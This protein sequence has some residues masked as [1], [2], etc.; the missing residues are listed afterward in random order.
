VNGRTNDEHHLDT[1]AALALGALS[2]REAADA[3]AHL[4]SCDD[5]RREYAMLRPTADAVGLSVAHDVPPEVAARMKSRV[6]DAVRADI[7]GR[8]PAF[9]VPP[10]PLDVDTG[11]TAANVIPFART[12]RRSFAWV[13]YVAAAA[14]FIFAIYSQG[15]LV[16][17]QVALSDATAQVTGLK[18]EVAITARA[19][20]LE[21]ATLADIAAPDAKRYDVPGRGTVIVRGGHAYLSLKGLPALPRGKVYEAWTLANGAKS[22][23]DVKR[24]VTF[25]PA[26]E[27]TLV[28][29]P[30]NARNVADVAIT[31]EPDGGSAKP[32]SAPLFIR[33]LG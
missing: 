4:A 1:T 26:P 22:L 21:R 24:S 2:A 30:E 11:D 14:A 20:V 5:C 17:T 15:R 27:N 16:S 18:S 7:A 23:A 31:V 3:R 13:G 25:S 9:S 6:M 12:Q 33:K 32:T 28:A 19:S 10:P 8:A 29:L